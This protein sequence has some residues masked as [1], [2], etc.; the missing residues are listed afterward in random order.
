MDCPKCRKAVSDSDYVCPYCGTKIRTEPEKSK[1]KRT[2]KDKSVKV[3]VKSNTTKGGLFK[4]KKSPDREVIPKSELLSKFKI[5]AVV[6]CIILIVILLITILFSAL[7]SKGEKYA[8][9]AAQYIGKDFSAIKDEDDIHFKDESACF[10]VNS[11]VDFD[12][13]FESDKKIKAQDI[14]YPQWA[15]TIS[16]ADNN[17]ITDVTY[18]NFS[19]IKKDM[20]GEKHGSLVN[21]DNF[22]EGCKQSSVTKYVDMTPYNIHYAQS[23]IVTYTYKYYYFRDNGDAQQVILRVAFTEDGKYKYYTS[24][25]IYPDNM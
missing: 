6:I 24:E 10:G 2:E 20:R 25:L 11:T 4:R 15:V 18:T 5:V 17:Y 8:D 7:S 19:V 3:K 16:L 13:I 23:G 12:Y 21:L 14:A 9:I 1:K 22:K